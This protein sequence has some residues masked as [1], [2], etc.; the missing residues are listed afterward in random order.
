MKIFGILSLHSSFFSSIVPYKFQ[1][2]HLLELNF[3][4][5]LSFQGY[6]FSKQTGKRLYFSLTK[7]RFFFFSLSTV[8]KIIF[9]S[10][11]RSGRDTAHYKIFGFPRLRLPLLWYDSSCVSSS[12][13]PL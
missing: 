7:V 4:P 13:V 10:R 3:D 9:P 8:I 11:Q 12:P 5:E 2:P 1:L 6:L